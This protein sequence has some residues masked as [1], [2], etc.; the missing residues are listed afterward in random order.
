M[1]GVDRLDA[2]LQGGLPRARTTLLTGDPGTRKDTLATNFLQAG[3]EQGERCLFVSTERTIAE[4]RDSLAPYEFGLD[5]DRRTV[6]IEFT[7]AGVVAS[8]ERRSRPPALEQHHHAPG[9]S[10]VSTG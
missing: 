9:G 1:T 7:D 5:H 2:A 10:T 8:P 4:L 3:P 6:E